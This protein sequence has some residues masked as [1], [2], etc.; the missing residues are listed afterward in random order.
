MPKTSQGVCNRAKACRDY[1]L[2]WRKARRGNSPI[3]RAMERA[4][5]RYLI[6]KGWVGRMP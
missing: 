2:M 4:G 6:R 1:V 5:L 3:C